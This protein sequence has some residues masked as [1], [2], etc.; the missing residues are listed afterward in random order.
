MLFG[1]AENQPEGPK[2]KAEVILHS[3]TE[4]VHGNVQILT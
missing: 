4:A 2:R 1:L 3:Q